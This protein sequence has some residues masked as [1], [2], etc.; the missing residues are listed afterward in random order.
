MELGLG[1]GALFGGLA[2]LHDGGV[3]ASAKV[4][5]ELVGLL[6]AVDVD[7]FA[8]GVDDH[9]AVVAGSEVFFDFRKEIGFDLSVEVVG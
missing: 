8:G 4:F 6:T 3:E 9:F 7:G 2:S 1:F 5:G